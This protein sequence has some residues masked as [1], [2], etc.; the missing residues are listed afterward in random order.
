MRGPRIVSRLLF[1]ALLA[2]FWAGGLFAQ[3]DGDLRWKA[4]QASGRYIVSS[5]AVAAD[6]T[7]F[8][9]VWIDSTPNRGLLL[10]VNARDG[11]LKWQFPKVTDPAIN[12][13]ESSP[14]ISPDG[15]TVYF[16]GGDGKLYAL[17]TATGTKKSEF[18]SSAAEIPNSPTIAADGTV[19]VV[20]SDLVLHALTSTLTERWKHVAGYSVSID[21]AVAIGGDGT[22]YTG[23]FDEN[24]YAL[25]SDGSEQWRTAAG[26]AILTSPVIS[27]DGTIYV[28]TSDNRLVA[29]TRAGPKWSFSVGSLILSAP[30]LAADG[31]IYFGATD[32]QFYA[33][34]PDGTVKW[35]RDLRVGIL[36]SPA[37]RG[38]G[39]IIFGANDNLVHAFNPDGSTKWTVTTGD[40]VQSSPAIA[41]DGTTYVG[42]FD[43]SL[44]A[45]YGNPSPISPLSSFSSWPMFNHDAA[46]SGRTI[47]ATG[48]AYLVNLST[49]GPA[50][51]TTNLIA[52]FVV[53]GTAAKKFLIRA[54]G[55]TLASSPFSLTGMLA[56]PALSVVAGGIEVAANDNWNDNFLDLVNV[57]NGLAFPLGAGEKDAAVV[58]SLA[59]ANYGAVV[60]SS[61]GGSGAALVEVYDAEAGSPAA[62]LVN[63]STRAQAGGGSGILTAGLV[64]GGSGSL[65]VLLRAI[66]PG[67]APFGVSGYLTQPT[68]RVFDTASREIGRNTGWTSGGLTED[69]AAAARLTGAFALAASGAGAAD[70]AAVFTLAPGNYTIQVGGVSGAAGEALVEVYVVP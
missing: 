18:T 50:G 56:D 27:P 49:L 60:K 8:V 28:G 30:S 34:N 42:S 37:V 70:C 41:A 14:A 48:N 39:T 32:N 67:L 53:R 66:G 20:S 63:L 40:Y 25:N 54:V 16:G 45:I 38:D 12:R 35:Q 1:A 4:V 69:L 44:Y 58:V 23:A 47:T 43:G 65:R 3:K 9:G 10:A 22:V 31:T 24:L 17:D 51:G 52:G 26:A 59:P 13:V 19:Y 15:S 33:L 7:I 21:T 55:P 5:P 46:H 68:M 29:L 57:T 64:I 2:A 6:G 62:R 61:D 36:T 11:S